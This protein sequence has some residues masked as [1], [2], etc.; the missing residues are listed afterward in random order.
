MNNA[1]RDIR[2]VNKLLVFDDDV[3]ELV[4]VEDDAAII[5]VSLRARRA[6]TSL[7]DLYRS[8]AMAD[9]KRRDQQIRAL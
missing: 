7:A 3:R 9:L 2:T 5:A 8:R 6:L 1:E 4:S